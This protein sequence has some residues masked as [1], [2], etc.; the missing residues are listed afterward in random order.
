MALDDGSL[1]DGLTDSQKTCLRLVHA[2][3]TSK[4]IA[5]QTG[6]TPQTVDQYMSRA[7][8]HLRAANRYQ[9]AKWLAEAEAEPIK[10]SEF[11]P[12]AI[13]PEPFSAAPMTTPA[14][15]LKAGQSANDDG[16]KPPRSTTTLADL[17]KLPPVGGKR[18]E[19][20][21]VGRTALVFRVAIAAIVAAAGLVAVTRGA[22]H[23]LS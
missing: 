6:L 12:Q 2:G 8:A 22:V 9:A 16:L 11:S 21:W 23:L 19:L 17:F 5:R 3:Q 1:L 14:I 20:D 7:V 13:A 4:E 15:D 10:V 18:H